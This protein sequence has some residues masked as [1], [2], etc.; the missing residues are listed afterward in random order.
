MFLRKSLSQASTLS[1]V[2]MPAAGGAAPSLHGTWSFAALPLT[3]PFA[4]TCFVWPYYRSLS[5]SRFCATRWC[6]RAPTA[7]HLAQQVVV[8]RL[9]HGSWLLLLPS[10]TWRLRGMD[11]FKR[12]EPARASRS[13]ACESPC[14]CRHLDATLCRW[15]ILCCNGHYAW[16]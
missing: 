12:C 5:I 3:S 13:D 16:V 14:L 1:R 11:L 4:A 15:T 7:Q 6:N 9:L 2:S 8:R 10:E